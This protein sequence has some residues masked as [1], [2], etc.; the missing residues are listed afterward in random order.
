LV[1]RARPDDLVLC[2]ETRSLLYL[3]YHAPELQRLR[4]LIVADEETFHYSDGILAVPA[5]RQITDQA[6]R[7]SRERGERWWGVRLRH[8]GRDGPRAAAL[9]DSLARGPKHTLEKVT[10][11]E[12]APSPG[13]GP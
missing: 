1:A 6:W 10:W 8:A 11:W 4:L 13:T 9:F 2:T 12:G 3:Q 7:E 5:E